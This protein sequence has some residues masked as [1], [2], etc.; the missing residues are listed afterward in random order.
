MCTETGKSGGLCCKSPGRLV[1]ILSNQLKR[2]FLVPDDGNE[3]TMLQRH[4]L[5]FII[6]GSMHQ[7]IFQKDVEAEF[8]I[9]KS[10][11]TGS[12][13]LLEKK[14]FIRRES[15][16][17]D[18]RLKRVLPTDKALA[19][20]DRVMQSLRSAEKQMLQGIDKED[21]DVCIQVLARMSRNLSCKEQDCKEQECR[22]T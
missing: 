16:E 14:G 19:M 4:M 3:L 1:N 18:G 6:V 22:L 17:R 13:Q 11:A 10:T 20:R 21:L 15:V 12:L 7:D 5:H 2:R 8:Q 9:R